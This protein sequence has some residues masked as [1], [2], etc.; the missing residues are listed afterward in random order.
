MAQLEEDTMEREQRDPVVLQAAWATAYERVECPC[1]PP[2]S[3]GIGV[4]A[5]MR[6]IEREFWRLLG[7]R[8]PC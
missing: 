8:T 5:K 3:T 1:C 7:R 2:P 6:R 4:Y